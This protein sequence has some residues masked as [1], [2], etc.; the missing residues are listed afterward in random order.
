MLFSGHGLTIA[1]CELTAAAVASTRSA[2]DEATN[3]PS[4]LEKE[5]IKSS[6]QWL[7]ESVGILW[8]LKEE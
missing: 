6:H 2:Q 3:Q 4:V 1:Q 8:L 5:E 7:E